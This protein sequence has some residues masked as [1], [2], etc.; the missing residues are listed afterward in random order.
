MAAPPGRIDAILADF[1]L[2]DDWEDRYRYVIEL[3]RTLEPLPDEARNAHNKVQG[4]VSQVWL[5][6][7][8]HRD[9]RNIR[10]TFIGDSDA[11]IRAASSVR[12]GS[13]GSQ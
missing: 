2:L 5:E 12:A 10:L 3:G 7:T 6:T 1:E 8:P 13:P 9:G 11:D 4:C